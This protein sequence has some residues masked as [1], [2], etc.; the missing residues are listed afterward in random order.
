[1]DVIIP[2][3][4]NVPGLYNTVTRVVIESCT[5]L[6]I[7]YNHLNGKQDRGIDFLE[8]LPNLDTITIYIV[9]QKD[10]RL[11][12]SA[13]VNINIKQQEYFQKVETVIL[14]DLVDSAYDYQLPDINQHLREA[15]LNIRAVFPNLI[16]LTILKIAPLVPASVIVH[17]DGQ[18][19]IK[20]CLHT[21]ERYHNFIV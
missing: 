5:H 4:S 14:A 1:M 12:A 8:N 3:T 10:D 17:A 11:F 16:N 2:E 21:R 9:S 15:T 6:G 19:G 7:V 13:Y 20:T 18:Q